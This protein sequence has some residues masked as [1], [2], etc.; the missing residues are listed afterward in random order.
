M[1][2][3]LAD[4]SR[5]NILDLLREQERAVGDLVAATGLSQPGVS[6]HLRVLRDAGLVNVR[7][8]G[9]RR[10]YR[11]RPEPLAEI[12]EWLAPYRAAWRD[13][14]GALERH[15]DAMPPPGPARRPRRPRPP[16]RRAAC[17]PAPAAPAAPAHPPGPTTRSADMDD[18]D[19]G[20]LARDGDQW[21]LT[22]TR[23]LAH[24]VEQVWRAVT[25]PEHLA[26]WFPQQIIGERRAGAP[27]RF[28][29]PAGDGFDGEML[30]F[31]PPTLLEL[32]WGGDRLR[33]ELRPD[34]PGTV[35]TLTDTF[36]ELGKAARDAA[37]WHECLD[38]LA[39]SL[40]GHPAARLGRDLAAGAP[41]LH[42]AAGTGSRHDRP[43]ARLRGA[44]RPPGLTR[45]GARSARISS[46]RASAPA[47]QGRA[48]G[49]AAASA[50][51]RCSSVSP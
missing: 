5:R 22:F 16:R 29:S 3:V 19:L 17:A 40:A 4:R 11:L 41:A 46:R 31:Q 47:T 37:G 28:V 36:G 33:I 23:R 18:A 10:L 50:V 38:R 6:K 48:S 44:R 12:E 8:E 32:T 7:A 27:L 39:A 45:Q 24:P 13:R 1:F 34:G 25:E 30:A 15:L 20:V 42:R 51:S 9:Q 14:L 49:S 43:A 21:T 2:E 35:L 26:A